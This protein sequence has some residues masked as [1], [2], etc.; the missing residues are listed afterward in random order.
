MKFRLWKKVRVGLKSIR[1][2]IL[3][4]RSRKGGSSDKLGLYE[5][6][7]AGAHVFEQVKLP[8]K[9]R[10]RI[11]NLYLVSPKDIGFSDPIPYEV[12]IEKAFT[13]GLDYCPA[14]LSLEMCVR[15]P[16]LEDHSH[17]H[18]VMYELDGEDGVDVT[19]LFQ[20]VA[21]RY[22]LSNSDTTPSMLC[23]PDQI[24]LFTGDSSLST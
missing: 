13:K 5:Y 14:A 15:K 16:D 10:V 8:S 17:V 4:A 18:V 6:S 9:V 3:E 24:Y 20:H 21:G 19:F 23:H 2:K 12:F 11:L 1:K 7:I 22:I